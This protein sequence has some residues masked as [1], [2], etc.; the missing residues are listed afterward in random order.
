MTIGCGGKASS[1]GQPGMAPILPS[2]P[3]SHAAPSATTMSAVPCTHSTGGF[4]SRPTMPDQSQCF[5]DSALRIPRVPGATVGQ[6]SDGVAS[7]G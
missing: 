7:P 1:P 6:F 4:R 5:G 3:I 2:V